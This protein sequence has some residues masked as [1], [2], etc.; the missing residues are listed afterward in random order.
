MNRPSPEGLHAAKVR[1]EEIWE[2]PAGGS[3]SMPYTYTPGFW[4]KPGW[5]VEPLP[6]VDRERLYSGQWAGERA[7]ERRPG[8]WQCGGFVSRAI[9]RAPLKWVPHEAM[10][11]F[12]VIIPAGTMLVWAMAWILSV[13]PW[14]G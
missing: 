2:G 6:G 10:V 14:P 4:M 5:G 12:L 13:L 1:E 7:P 9:C 8:F 11:F 3:K